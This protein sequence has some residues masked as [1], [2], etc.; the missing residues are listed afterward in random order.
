MR[1]EG[2]L[3][4]NPFDSNNFALSRM[5]KHSFSGPPKSH[6][7]LLCAARK[8][9]Q[10]GGPKGLIESPRALEGSCVS[11]FRE[12]YAGYLIYFVSKST[13]AALSSSSVIGSVATFTVR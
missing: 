3:P 1:C 11:P 6:E 12:D 8:P 2:P 10:K 5:H 9:A 4:F 13:N 7:T